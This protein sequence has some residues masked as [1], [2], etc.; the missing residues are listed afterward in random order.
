MAALTEAKSQLVALG[1]IFCLG[2]ES[3]GKLLLQCRDCGPGAV[4]EKY[5]SWP[6]PSLS[7]PVSCLHLSENKVRLKTFLSLLR[8]SLLLF[9]A[10]TC[11]FVLCQV[12]GLL[13]MG[14]GQEENVCIRRVYDLNEMSDGI[15]GITLGLVALGRELLG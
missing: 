10:H 15:D 5:K 7:H 6:I 14:K 9:S 4:Q 12:L 2:N 3:V 11:P 1:R 8:F 13:I